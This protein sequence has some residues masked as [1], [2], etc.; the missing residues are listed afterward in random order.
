M[1]QE[2][3]FRLV[4]P[5]VFPAGV[6]PGAGK[7]GGNRLQIARDGQGRPTLRG[8]ALA[9]ALRHAY[10]RSRGIRSNDPQVVDW[11]G[12]AHS[13]EGEYPSLLRVDDVILDAGDQETVARHH[14]A[15]NRHTGAVRDGSLFDVEALPPGTRG[16]ALLE[17]AADD[18]AEAL[19]FLEELTGL[20]HQGFILGG[21]GSRG[22][23]R[24]EIEGDAK[25]RDFN[26]SSIEDH[27]A[28]LDE[29]YAYRTG[30]MPEG[31]EVLS[32][33]V[34]ENAALCVNLVLGIPRGQDVLVGGGQAL[35]YEME[36][37]RVT[38]S[39]GKIYWRLPGSSLRGVFRGWFSRLAARDADELDVA[40]SASRFMET[41]VPAKGDEIAWGFHDKESRKDLIESLAGD[42][43]NLD[44][45]ITCPIMR[46]FG[47][48]FS[49]GRIHIS[50][51]FADKEPQQ[52]QLR[53]H[54]AIDSFTGGA[55]EGF[56]FQNTVLLGAHFPVSITIERPT[57]KEATW[58]AWTI[59][60]LN[61]GILRV[62]CSKASGR[63]A[64]VGDI[65]AKGPYYE[66]FADL[67]SP[68]REG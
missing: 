7:S 16:K 26:L 50:D 39:D 41:G 56:F 12:C 10:A 25:F 22:I 60:A 53:A 58:L 24:V 64:L 63:L 33:K 31:G 48:A 67:G 57:E 54:V 45:E 35:D 2:L 1:E 68:A 30:K 36:P 44:N 40:D 49:R 8:T 3:V 47:S 37:Q 42:P 62:G 5:L 23:G 19:Q 4:L 32:P 43:S 9:G 13:K 28:F 65:K 38:G 6:H 17:L 18:K 21:G 61:T 46:L 55:N 29:R 20:F 15:V 51:S 34:A 66:K 27:A 14:N 11:F 52:E 59:R